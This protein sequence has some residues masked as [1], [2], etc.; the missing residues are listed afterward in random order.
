MPAS[1]TLL[2]HTDITYTNNNNF[3]TVRGLAANLDGSIM[4]LAI[5]GITGY[6]IL[7]SIDH[8]QTWQTSNPDNSGGAWGITSIACSSDGTI[9]YAANLGQGLY[10]STN[11]GA[12]WSYI[13]SGAPLP[14]GSG[15]PEVNAGYSTYN[16]YQVSCDGTGQ[17]VLMTTN[18]SAV[19]YRSTDGGSTWTNTYTIPNY[20]GH[21]IT[22]ILVTSNIDGTIIYAAWN[23]T[24]KKLYKSTDH[25]QTWNMI[26]TMGDVEG[27]FIGISTNSTGDFLFATDNVG[28]LH[29]FYET[30]AAKTV[31]PPFNG[32][33]VTVCSS[34]NNGNN[35]IVVINDATETYLVHNLFPPAPYP[36]QPV[37]C[38]KE[39][40]MILCYTDGKEEYVKIQEIR[41]GDLVRTV[42]HGYVPVNMIGTSTMYNPGHRVRGKD[43]LYVCKPSA[44]PELTSD[45]IITGCHSILSRTITPIQREQTI[46]LLGRIMITDNN[47]RIMACIDERAEPYQE[48][49]L[50]TI[51]HLALDHED[52]R[53]NYGIYANGL[54]VETC[55][56]RFLKEY[57]GMVLIE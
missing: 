52:I 55:S 46:D 50:H 37:T 2:Q 32:S 8:G 18:Y 35:V 25:G 7:K 33:L 17:Q 47:Y 40:S 26:A 53:M 49:G 6:G 43:R 29:I 13:T 56:K 51:W 41:K 28:A 11:S 24:D 36:G 16:V 30:H 38:F 10:K 14:G 5:N 15:N 54:L 27:P 22:P 48:E 23:D 31:L 20:S 3:T 4:Y 21:P 12:T 42:H 34:Y 57:S 39:D 1:L 9:V 19:V 45:L 44:Y